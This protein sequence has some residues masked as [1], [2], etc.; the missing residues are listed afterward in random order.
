MDL[1]LGYRFLLVALIIALNGFFSSA[2]VAL[3]SVR[4]SRLRQ[5]AD[6]GATGA[7]AALSLLANPERLL[8]VVQVGVTLA[9]LGL[10]WAGEDTVYALMLK[11]IQPVETPQIATALH[12]VA[13]TLS[14][15]LI[16]Y[17]HVVIGEV[18]P[19]NLAIDKADRL[20]VLVAPTLL[21]FS[22]VAGPFV[23]VIER[24]ASVVSRAIGLT[25]ESQ[26]AS[27]TPEEIKFIVGA[28]RKHGF[29]QDTEEGAIASLLDLRELSAREIM[30]PRGAIAG[31]PIESDLDDLLRAFHE[32]KYSRM[33]IYERSPEHVVGIVYAKDLLGVWQQ[34]RRANQRRRPAPQFDIKRLLR[35]PEVVPET[36]PVLQLMETFRSSG[37]HMA[38]V[39][40]EFGSVTGLV[41]LEDVLE[42]IFGDIADEHDVRL[43]SQTEVWEELEL[44][45][46]TRLRD[47][48]TQYLIEL[49]MDADYETLAG[50]LLF[51]L[52]YIP[53]PGE[54]VEFQ[55]LR[56]TVLEMDRNRIVKVKIERVPPPP[57]DPATE[58][59][60][61]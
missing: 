30:T 15:L 39:V 17:M 38:L 25:G 29:L 45:G 53:I 11:V 22:R 31:A 40:D 37:R 47:L 27:H 61:S 5:L 34:R 32:N 20:A 44:E 18:V 54:T 51:R 43:P 41:T 28:A 12:A 58:P 57:A 6:E 46:I 52:G 49:P 24:S 35:Q 14:F 56:F 13:F 8:S 9:S 23:T 4:Q 36:K 2:E 1:H 50:F 55:D 16:T 7:H 42:Q 10:G 21:F 3:L 48:E 19:K 60:P 33:P 26:T 59:Q